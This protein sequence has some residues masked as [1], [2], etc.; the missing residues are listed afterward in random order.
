MQEDLV[1]Y[2]SGE[3]SKFRQLLKSK[4]DLRK[5]QKMLY[6]MLKKAENGRESDPGSI[7]ENSKNDEKE[8]GQN[9]HTASFRRREGRGR[10]LEAATRNDR[11]DNLNAQDQTDVT[12][13]NLLGL[14]SGDLTG[15]SM[16]TEDV[17]ATDRRLLQK[18]DRS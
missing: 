14:R 13:H 17:A 1:P 10:R 16:V 7:S 15:I 18:T 9:R 8:S 3:S 12:G 11:D 5:M 2:Q 4:T 6:S